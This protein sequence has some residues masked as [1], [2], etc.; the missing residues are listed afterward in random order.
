MHHDSQQ[1]LISGW[2]AGMAASCIVYVGVSFDSS[3]VCYFIFVLRWQTKCDK[4]P[5][6]SS[7]RARLGSSLLSAEA[8]L[9][10]TKTYLKAAPASAVED[11]PKPCAGSCGF[12]V[13][14]HATHC[15]SGCE[16]QSGG[17]H[18]PECEMKPMPEQDGDQ[19]R[20]G[21]LPPTRG[22]CSSR[23]SRI[24]IHSSPSPRA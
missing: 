23:S 20:H 14:C 5:L 4:G 13:T 19:A 18:G 9:L 3:F 8:G 11:G 7:A 2:L 15:C 6:K 10:A 1:E 16:A 24:M 21:K 12:Q 22:K 17:A